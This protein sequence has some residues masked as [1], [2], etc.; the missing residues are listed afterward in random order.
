MRS[1]RCS[2][3]PRRDTLAHAAALGPQGQRHAERMQALVQARSQYVAAHDAV[4]GTKGMIRWKSAENAW[5]D[6]DELVVIRG[7]QGET[8]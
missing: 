5:K 4:R 7:P 3:R 1:V 6:L 2:H 8:R